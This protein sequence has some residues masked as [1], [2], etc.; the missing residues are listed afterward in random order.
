M[1]A[2]ERAVV[3]TRRWGLAVAVAWGV[4]G[5]VAHPPSI[6]PEPVS[7]VH[8]DMVAA[9]AAIPERATS[10]ELTF[11][12]DIVL[13]VYNEW[14]GF[15]ELHA[16]DAD[17]F[18]EVVEL[19]AADVVVGNLESPIMMTLPEHPPISTRHRY[20]GS[21]AHLTQ[22]SRA[23]FTVLSLANNHYFDLG[24][25]GQLETPA[26]LTELGLFPIGAGRTEAPRLRVDSLEVQGWRIGFLACT[27]VHNHRGDP[28]GPRVP[29]L[30]FARLDEAVE[31]L[32][33]ARADHDL[34]IVVVHWGAEHSDVVGTSH[35]YAARKLVDAGVDLIV[36]HHPHVLQAID[37]HR[38]DD[39]RDVLVAHSLGNF[40]FPRATEPSNL[41]GVLRVEYR[42]VPGE[43]PCLAQA[44]LHPVQVVRK[45]GWHPQ[46]ATDD[47]AS[48][49]RR[50]IIN[51]SR[52][53]GTR[54]ERATDGEDLLVAELVAC[55]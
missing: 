50:R 1:I 46:P 25:P 53:H 19:L 29:L 18:V 11:V 42:D 52:R 14:A 8:I 3:V 6:E 39:G 26:Q 35:T 47:T 21:A 49:V 33:A 30:S 2:R 37:V 31:A 20:A 54:F 34:L 27:T 48:A 44:R 32:E 5:C 13:G 24:V 9:A 23:G 22:L 12:G 10:L 51:V 40:L 15:R 38:R 4:V 28:E 43:R 41:S 16:P 55:E 7:S 36:G 45:P 17:P